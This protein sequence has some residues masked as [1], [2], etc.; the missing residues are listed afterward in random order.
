LETQGTAAILF[1]A[2]GFQTSAIALAALWALSVKKWSIYEN[3]K[4]VV[5][6]GK[7]GEKKMAAR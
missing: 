5:R 2:P 4:K 3:G 7:E 6:I 1:L